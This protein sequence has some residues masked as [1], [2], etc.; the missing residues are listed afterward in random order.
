VRVT[1]RRNV[2]CGGEFIGISVSMDHDRF[3]ES[4]R[5]LLLMDPDENVTLCGDT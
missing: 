1:D 4:Y 3:V 2:I 5:H